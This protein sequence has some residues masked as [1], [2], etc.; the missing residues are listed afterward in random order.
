MHD[1][2]VASDV[3]V[4]KQH[5][6]MVAFGKV[7]MEILV[8]QGPCKGS[9]MKDGKKVVIVVKTPA[10]GITKVLRSSERGQRVR[11]VHGDSWATTYQIDSP[12]LV[13][14]LPMVRQGCVL[15]EKV[16]DDRAF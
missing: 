2:L 5:L 9:Q 14:G 16:V 12:V 1:G 3:F 4:S 10:R 6:P 11:T 7:V 8:V 13:K 15:S